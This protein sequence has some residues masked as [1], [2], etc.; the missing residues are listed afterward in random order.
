MLLPEQ[1]LPD[2]PAG[3]AGGSKHR[4]ADFPMAP[5]QW[6]LRH[7]ADAAEFT[8]GVSELTRWA[9]LAPQALRQAQHAIELGIRLG[10]A[11]QTTSYEELGIY[12]LLLQIGDMQQL[13]QF[14]KDVLGS[15]TRTT[16]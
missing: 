12:R 13:W 4:S 15:L 10:R 6:L 1:L 7:Q 3:N 8:C 11:G 14:A 9:E 5:T 16:G 2:T